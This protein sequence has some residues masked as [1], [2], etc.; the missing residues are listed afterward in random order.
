MKIFIFIKN[1][2]SN[3]SGFKDIFVFNPLISDRRHVS[4]RGLNENIIDDDI[5]VI[6]RSIPS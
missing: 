2:F 4:T 1:K 5:F 3:I 6:D